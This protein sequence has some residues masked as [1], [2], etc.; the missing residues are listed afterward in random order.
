[1]RRVFTTADALQNG[2][3]EAGLLTGERRG[4]W[5]KLEKGVWV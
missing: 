1:M 3:T 2:L 5:R 4:R